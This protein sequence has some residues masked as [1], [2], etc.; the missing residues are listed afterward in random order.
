MAGVRLSVDDAKD[1]KKEGAESKGR[2]LAE[3]VGANVVA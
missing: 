3:R 1:A 2:G